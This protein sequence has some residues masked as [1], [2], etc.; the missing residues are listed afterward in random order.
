MLPWSLK[1]RLLGH[2]WDEDLDNGFRP[3][4]LIRL[5]QTHVDNVQARETTGKV[6]AGECQKIPRVKAE[7]LKMFKG[8]AFAQEIDARVWKRQGIK[9][10]PGQT[11]C[12]TSG[13]Y[14]ILLNFWQLGMSC[15]FC[16]QTVACF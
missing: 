2:E 14:S 12:D 15:R 5:S 4:G 6:S 11:H 16:L 9:D 1:A 8:L 7:L 10:V 13:P 3:E